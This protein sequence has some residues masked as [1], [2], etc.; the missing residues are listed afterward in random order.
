MDPPR[1]PDPFTTTRTTRTV[2]FLFSS[3]PSRRPSTL[4]LGDP[5]LRV[6]STRRFV[7]PRPPTPAPLRRMSGYRLLVE[8]DVRDLLG[9]VGAEHV[10]D[11][12][13]RCQAGC[14]STKG[15]IRGG[16]HSAA[17]APGLEGGC[18]ELYW[19]EKG[20]HRG[21]FSCGERERESLGLWAGSRWSRASRDAPT[22][23]LGFSWNCAR[24]CLVLRPR[25]GGFLAMLP[26][27]GPNV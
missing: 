13:V 20:W 10:A 2:P 7:G 25:P 26:T 14:E 24:A 1:P 15:S 27:P 18:L 6:P 8:K 5:A 3:R 9:A 16:C 23:G 12:N 4:S 11:P 21:F 22:V 17:V 19:S